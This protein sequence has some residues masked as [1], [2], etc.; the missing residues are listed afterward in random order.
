MQLFSGYHT[1]HRQC[2]NPTPVNTEEGCEGSSFEVE[3]CKDDK[4]NSEN[5]QLLKHL[6]NLV[7][8]TCLLRRLFMFKTTYF[9]V[10][11]NGKTIIL[12][13]LL[14]YN[15]KRNYCEVK[16]DWYVPQYTHFAHLIFTYKLVFWIKKGWLLK[17][18]PIF[19][20]CSW[21]NKVKWKLN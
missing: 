10:F 12:C 9:G 17:Q 2:N 14:A 16:K 1:K 5:N 20:R 21:E 6:Q 18:E 11:Q 7:Q 19:G 15:T 4:V 8:T 13:E 3:L